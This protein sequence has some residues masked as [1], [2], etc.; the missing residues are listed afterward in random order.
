[1][2]T[3]KKMTGERNLLLLL[4]ENMLAYNTVQIDNGPNIDI[5][6]YNITL[7]NWKT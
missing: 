2:M 3:L 7:K 1:M 6:N 4:I 5:P